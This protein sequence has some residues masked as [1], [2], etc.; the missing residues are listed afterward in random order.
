M[1]KAVPFKEYLLERLKDK[2]FSAEYLNEALNDEDPSVFLLAL[3]DVIEAQG[4]I[5]NFAKKSDLN[6]EN[7]YKILSEKGNP[8]LASIIKLLDAA[9]FNLGVRTK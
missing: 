6:R 3:K 2:E 8:F 5:G 1:S 7:L 9:G 4:G